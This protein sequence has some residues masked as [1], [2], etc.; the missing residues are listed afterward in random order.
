MIF[1]NAIEN[2]LFEKLS[3]EFND[4]LNTIPFKF[5]S[6]TASANKDRS[7]TDSSWHHML[8]RD[9]VIY[10]KNF[11]IC[12]KCFINF[13]DN[14]NQKI[15]K[16]LRMRVG[17]ITAQ[18][19]SLIHEP[20]TDYPFPHKTALIYL[21]DSDGDTFLYDLFYDPHSNLIPSQYYKQHKDNLKTQHKIKPIANR[22][23]VFDG[24]QY[25]SS[26]TPVENSY[27]CVININYLVE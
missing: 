10:S 4:N 14:T 25:H 16:L 2:K 6:Q 23:V 5:L 18:N 27:R 8:Y 9:G 24:L 1:D 7:A 13:L 15:T 12:N 19:K 11:N 22:V 17:F 20:H 26:S 3:F 21:N